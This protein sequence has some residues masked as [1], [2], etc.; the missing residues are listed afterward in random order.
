MPLSDYILI[1]EDER[2]IAE[3]LK[4]VLCDVLPVKMAYNLQ[5]AYDC[6][7]TKKPKLILLDLCLPDSH[8]GATYRDIYHLTPDV[9]IFILSSRSK[10]ELTDFPEGLVIF[11]PQIF[12]DELSLKQFQENIVRALL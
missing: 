2:Y 4:D 9:K 7:L 8:G 5:E 10:L 6:I 12:K 11:K 1:V 3:L